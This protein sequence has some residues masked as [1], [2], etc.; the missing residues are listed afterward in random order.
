MLGEVQRVLRPGG[1]YVM[2]SFSLDAAAPSAS[3]AAVFAA[4]EPARRGTLPCLCSP[5]RIVGL[6][7][8]SLWS[9]FGIY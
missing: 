1:L 9:I 2:I 7:H 8:A 5:H 6:G 3:S 4:F